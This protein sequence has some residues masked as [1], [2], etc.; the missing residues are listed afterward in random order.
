M[1]T[2]KYSALFCAVTATIFS[3]S[4]AHANESSKGF[5]E[6]SRLDAK[7]RNVYFNRDGRDESPYD[8]REWV[9]GLHLN[10][11]SGYFADMIGFDMSYYGAWDLDSPGDSFTH[12]PKDGRN[13]RE[14]N[15]INK[16]GQAFVKFKYGND[17]FNVNIKHGRQV[18]N[19]NLIQ[20]SSSR[21]APSSLYGTTGEVNIGELK[22]HG[23][24]IT[25]HS[26]RSFGHFEHFYD[27]SSTDANTKK[28]NYIQAYGL[29]YQFDNGIG[30][31]YDWGKSNDFQKANLYKIH[32][33]MELGDNNK[34][35]LEGIHHTLESIGDAFN[36]TFSNADDFESKNTSFL[37]QLHLDAATYRLAYQHTAKGD[38][39]YAW[40]TGEYYGGFNSSIP[41]WSDFAYKDEKAIMVGFTYDFSDMGVPGLEFDINYQR[42]FDLD[43]N[44]NGLGDTIDRPKTEWG[45]DMTL[46]YAFQDPTLKGLS[47][48]WNNGTYR[49]SKTLVSTTEDIDYNRIYIDYVFDI[50]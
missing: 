19:D 38:F 17:D 11:H 36:Q 40:E 33:T 32:Y 48:S 25:Q 2:F 37:A 12:L 34:L 13:Q 14:T 7:L 5:L 47:V 22:L 3:F 35:Y 21:A 45:R 30:I 43:K 1:H 50:F 10:Y 9:Q 23:A 4:N 18:Y 49:G 26:W 31:E 27:G 16:I 15:D 41:V 44:N 39:R 42:G 28:V 20:G 6:G 8:N 46:S 29:A 24:Y